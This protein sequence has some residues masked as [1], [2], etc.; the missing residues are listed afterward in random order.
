VRRRRALAAVAAIAALLAVAAQLTGALGR[1]ESWTVDTRFALRGSEPASDVAVVALDD[2]D[3]AA[4]G[5]WPIRRTWHARA[6]DRLRRAGARLIAYDVQFTEAGPPGLEAD[7]VALFDA[8]SRAK[9]MVLAT[10]TVREDGDTDVLGGQANLGPAF[11]R[12]ANSLLPTD[13]GGGIRRVPY[14]VNGMTSFA[15]AAAEAASARDVGPEGFGGRS[16][17][18]IDFHGPPGTVPTY[19][20]RALLQG[21][22]PA[23]KLRGRVVVVGASA[24]SLQDVHPVP[25][26]GR[27]TMPGPEVQANAISTVLRGLPLRTSPWWLDALAALALAF[28]VPL[29]ALRLSAAVAAAIGL[30]AL[31]AWVV[32]CQLAFDHGLVLTATPP[33]AGFIVGPIG[34]ISAAAMLS[35]A[36]RRRTRSI[37]GRFV[38]AP[39]VEA[40]LAREGGEARVGGVR[41]DA[42]VLFCDLRGFTTFAED[43]APE[44]V[45]EVLNHYLEQ[46][47][48]AVLA[49]GGTVVSYLGDGV[50]AV[51]GSPLARADH[52]TAAVAAADD[53]LAIRL[54]RFNAWLDERGL[55]PFALGAGLNSG[56]VMS[57]LVGSERRMEYAAVGDTTNVA[58]RL[59]AAT[60]GTPHA[61]YIAAST[62]DR[63]DDATRARLAPVT[64]VEVRGRGAAVAV[65]TLDLSGPGARLAA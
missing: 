47:S 27:G 2:A 58:A 3:I 16:G 29:A 23:S 41:Q 39:V 30:A 7:D 62:H 26:S 31:A 33:I 10:T 1:V 65:Y 64:T 42:T 60:K 56:P 19:S 11:A 36:D 40:L 12:A 50:M 14:L 25:T 61:L 18:L 13:V 24:P 63:L 52:A 9:G 32:A 44:L 55:P 15:V 35:V 17:A 53:L 37:F 57:G 54:P 38:P 43:A 45:I 51:F 21:R 22:V 8:V 49:H 4:Y 20:F 34:T 46:V 28:V 48:D 6:I 59:Q 5:H